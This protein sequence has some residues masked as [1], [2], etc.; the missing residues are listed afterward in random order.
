MA[1][2]LER[3]EGRYVASW[4]APRRSR[5][6]RTVPDLAAPPP[7]H[8]PRPDLP[9]GRRRTRYRRFRHVDEDGHAVHRQLVAGAGLEDHAEDD[10]AGVD[11]AGRA[12]TARR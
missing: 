9:V 4:P 12:L 3:F 5:G 8:A 10:S 6:S 1:P 2:A 7:A 11:R